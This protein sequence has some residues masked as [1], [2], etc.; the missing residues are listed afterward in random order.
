MTVHA[1]ETPFWR[2]TTGIALAVFLGVVG[3]L[4]VAEHWAHVAGTLPLLLPVLICLVM[5]LFMHG[6]HGGHDHGGRRE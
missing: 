1:P 2:S 5:H 3:I 4:L 6:G